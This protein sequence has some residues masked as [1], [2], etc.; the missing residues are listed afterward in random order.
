M[1]VWTERT[2]IAQ[3]NIAARKISLYE[4]VLDGK[5]R[6][7]LMLDRHTGS[8]TITNIRTT[9]SGLY[10]LQI[11][12]GSDVIS[13]SFSIIVSAHLPIPHITTDC[14]QYSS[15][16]SKCVL[17]CSVMNVSHDASLS[18]YKG[19]S[20]LSSISVSD[21]NIR[22]SLPLEVEYQDSNTYRC[23][24]NN[25]ITDHTQHLNIND[26]C[27][28]CS[29]LSDVSEEE[30]LLS[31]RTFII[32]AFV[33]AAFVV[34][35]VVM[36][37][38]YK[39]LKKTDQHGHTSG[40][41]NIEL[42]D[43]TKTET[44]KYIKVKAGDPVKLDTGVTDIQRFDLI[45]WKFGKLNDTTSPFISINRINKNNEELPKNDVT[46]KLG[47]RLKVIGETGSITI[48]KSKTTDT[49]LYK[50]EIDSST[51]QISKSFFV[52]VKE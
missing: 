34:G 16:S 9:D 5:F 35:A 28:K 4:D 13:R 3:H 11:L 2:R 39:R 10:E 29:E 41:E 44:V 40:P 12:R 23:V 17:L 26:V 14:S 33:V 15:L 50:L 1:G 37:F 8:L 27:H 47:D 32:G 20:L 19:N 38:I 42:I 21:L 52:T 7:R 45:Q 22:L 30:V 6:Q 43:K 48:E 46:K 31:H 18:W 25:P 51:D 36:I 24:I 49:G